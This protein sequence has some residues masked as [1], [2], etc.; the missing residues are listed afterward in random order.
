MGKIIGLTEDGK[1]YYGKY[2]EV[3]GKDE[4]YWTLVPS[5]LKD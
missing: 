4:I 1:I 2:M 5:S 3:C